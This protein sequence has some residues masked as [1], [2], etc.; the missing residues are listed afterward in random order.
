[1]NADKSIFRFRIGLKE[2]EPEIWRRI[3]VPGSYTFWDLHV[4]IQDAMGW[5]D[6][7]LHAFRVVDPDSGEKAE[8][9]IPDE[10][11]FEDGVE[12]KAGWE[13]PIAHYFR[14]AGH[15]AEYEYDFG[16][17]WI[18]EIVLEDI[19]GKEPKTKYP[20]CLA[21]ER[22]CPPED[23]GGPY[24][25]A[26]LLEILADKDH[27]Q[28][29]SMMEWIGERFGPDEFDPAGVRFDNPKKRWDIAFGDDE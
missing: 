6:Y 16:D 5:H 23:C 22:A 17:G 1:M 25:Y 27:E 15:R 9:G 10:E 13:I 14:Q 2:I 8:I 18:H 12:F 3:E 11:A 21:G 19:A 29:E 24:G 7:H 20:R 28:H 26:E 4:A